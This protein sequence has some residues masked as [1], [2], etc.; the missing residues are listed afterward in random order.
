MG[1]RFFMLLLFLSPGLWAQ[2]LKKGDPVPSYTF[3]QGINV[4]NDLLSLDNLKGKP[5]II[6]FWATW[7]AP[8]IPAMKKM[9]KQQEKFGSEVWFLTVSSETE[10]RL[11]KFLEK[12]GTTLPV[13]RD[14]GFRSYVPYQFIPHT[15]VID[16]KGR[17]AAVTSPWQVTNDIIR[18]LISGKE[19]DVKWKDDFRTEEGDVRM[20][21]S[22]DTEEASFE[23]T[24]YN[25]GQGSS[26]EYLYNNEDRLHG[27]SFSNMTFPEIFSNV[28]GLSS[29]HR[30]VYGRGL[31]ASD[32]THDISN[33]FGFT[34]RVSDEN[35][36][37]LE[38]RATSF[39]TRKTRI[40][41]RKTTRKM[42]NYVL[43]LNDN[44]PMKYSDNELVKIVSEGHIEIHGYPVSTLISFLEE[45]LGA[46]VADQTGLT[47][48]L[49]IVLDWD[50]DNEAEL[51]S[52]LEEAGYRLDRP[53]EAMETEVV[54]LYLEK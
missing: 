31:S 44:A 12:K 9:E 25:P 13:I 54:E 45:Y 43:R 16:R 19:I 8:C 41:S 32:F 26:V 38:E 1:L 49:S 47:G 22:E 14:N 7:C 39:I 35:I 53:E 42:E 27:Y 21:A 6:E 4:E 15:V 36:P 20:I 23:L 46:P 51:F 30:I 17:L 37:Y 50:A 18:D 34:C 5:V 48:N 29:V 10:A 52:A 24:T 40:G 28:Y 3:E 2:M 11:T 33:L